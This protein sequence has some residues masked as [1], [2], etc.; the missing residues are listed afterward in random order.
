MVSQARR[1]KLKPVRNP[2]VQT[3][4]LPDGHVVLF[5]EEHAWAH[6]LS[7]LAG[8]AWEYCDGELSFDEIVQQVSDTA[9]LQSADEIKAQL[10]ELFD[11]LTTAGLLTSPAA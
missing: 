3:K 10:E 8:I 1:V 7:P 6:T 11:S 9:G 4:L 5:C 2:Q